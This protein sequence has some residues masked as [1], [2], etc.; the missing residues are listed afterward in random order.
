MTIG[1]VV[2]KHPKAAFV[3]MDYGLHCIGCAAAL[4]ETIEQAAKVHRFGLKK[5]LSDLNKAAK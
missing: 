3:F 4:N 5:F 1:E 2:Q